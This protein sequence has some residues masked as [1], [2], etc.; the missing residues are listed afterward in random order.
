MN[1]RKDFANFLLHRCWIIIATFAIVIAGSAL[2]LFLHTEPKLEPIPRNVTVLI[3]A[4]GSKLLCDRSA[5]FDLNGSHLE[6]ILFNYISAA[7]DAETGEQHAVGNRK[8][9]DF[10]DEKAYRQW[11][12]NMLTGLNADVRYN[13]AEHF[14]IIERGV[15]K[16][17]QEQLEEVWQKI[18]GV[19]QNYEYSAQIWGIWG[20][21]VIRAM[22]VI[23]DE[24][25][26]CLFGFRYLD[27]RRSRGWRARFLRERD[28]EHV[29]LHL[30]RLTHHL[31]DLGDVKK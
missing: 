9:L 29:D 10:N 24:F 6:V 13:N 26:V 28:L 20:T 11:H 12:S 17:S 21:R 23:D 2:W 27:S 8:P 31:I 19:V 15:V 18:D 16:L 7:T 22:A 25:Y 1:L 3:S 30:L 14:S 5:F 4:S